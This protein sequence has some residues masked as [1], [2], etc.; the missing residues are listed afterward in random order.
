MSFGAG[1]WRYF[2]PQYEVLMGTEWVISY[3]SV[4]L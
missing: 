1:E 2:K 4:F 3:L